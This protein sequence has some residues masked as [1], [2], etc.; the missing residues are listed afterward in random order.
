VQTELNAEDRLAVR[1]LDGLLDY[2]EALV[3][4][5]ER[6]AMRLAQHK[7]ADGSQFNL[8]QHELAGLPGITLDFSDADGPIWLCI[9]RL[10]R[11]APPPVSAECQPWIEVSNDPVK[12][13]I[14]REVRHLRMPEIEMTR[15]AA[16]GEVRT[17]D[18]MVSSKV[19]GK[20]EPPGNYFDVMLRLEDR[21]AVADALEAYCTV[22]WL[23]WSEGEKPSRRSITVYQRLFEIAQRLLQSGGHESVELIWGL[24]VA[25]W[26][27]AGESIDLPMIERGVEIEIA[28][29]S[30]AAITIR[31]RATPAR[32]EL[33]PFEKLAAERLALAEDAARRCLRAIEGADSDGVSPFR[34]ETFEPLLK[35]CGSQLDPDGRY[36]P[37]HR[38]LASTEPVPVAE[39]EILTVTDRYVLFA[40]RRSSNSVL[41]DIERFKT[42]LAPEEGEPVILKGSTRTLVM[43]PADGIDDA[44]QP[45]TDRIEE[46]NSAGAAEAEPID[47]DHGDLFFP[48]PFNDD[49]VEIIRRLEKSDGLVVQGPPGTGKTHTIA[50]IICHMLATGRRVLVVSH[51]ETALKVIRDQLPE[52]VRDLTISVTTSEREGLKQVEKA[53]GLMLGIVNLVDANPSRQRNLILNFQSS[54]AAGRRRLAE[55]DSKIA[56]IAA[57]HLSKIPG[58]SETPYEAAKRV[59]ADRPLY[60]WFT[61][62]PELH[63]DEAGIDEATITVLAEARKRIGAD[64]HFLGERFPSPANLPDPAALM[65][66][67]RDLIAATS[68]SDGVASSEPLLRRVVTKLGAQEAER[69]ATELKE[70]AVSVLAAMKE[71][72]AWTLVELQRSDAAIQRLRPTALAFLA[73]AT[74]LVEQ[75]ANFV[76]RPVVLP[77]GL[78]PRPQCRQIFQSFGEGKNPFGLLAFKLKPHQE[79]IAQIRLSGLP[80]SKPEDWRH[81][82][83]YM[84]F[85]DRV[86][87]LSARWITLRDEM[88][89]PDH[90]HFSD[91]RL[92][93]L[94]GIADRLQ[95][96]LITLP[97]AFEHATE[98]LANA[99]GNRDEAL[100]ILRHHTATSTFGEELGRYVASLRL[101]AVRENVERTSDAFCKNH[102]N[103]SGSAIQVLRDHIG[104]P[105][106]D[107]RQLE[108]VWGAL[109]AKLSHLRGLETS[110]DRISETCN[111]L[112][113]AGAPDWSSRL[114][115]EPAS[116]DGDPVIR[117]DW[118]AAWDWAAKLS[119]LE[120]IGA[121]NDLANLHRER[122]QV[123]S[124]L[125]DTFARLV[126]E[127]TFFNLAASMKGT[128]K[129]ALRAFADI[130]RRL[131]S[132]KG[133]RA[134]LYRQDSRRAM[135]N[136]YD[137]VPCWIMPTWR[138]SEQLPASFDAFDLV[139]LDE[140][141]QSD[142]RELPAL[143]RGR[144]ILVVGDDRQ[145]SPSA[146]FLSIANIGRLRENFLSEFPYRAQVE[147]G[148]S[149]YD[150]SRVMFPDK[151]VMLKEHFRCVEPIIRFSMQF[152]NEPLIPLR[153]PRGIERL[154]PPLIDILVEDGERRGKS[155]VNPP[156]AEV[157]IDEIDRIINDPTLANFAGT[158]LKPRSIG[159]ISLIGSE[160]AAFIQK[161]LMDRIG[162]AAI[163]RHRIVCGD[164]ATFQ[165]D[166]RDIIFLSMIAD[167]KRKQSQTATQYEQRFN[168]ALSRARDRMILVRSVTEN[169]LNPNDLKS[170]IIGHFRDPI[171]EALQRGAALIELCQSGFERDLFSALVERGYR[172]IPQVGSQ[173][174]SIDMVIEG[175]AGRR[176][177]VECDGDLY[178]GPER[179]A[180]D[181][182]RQR[183]L[184]RVG[185]TF[186]RTFG[187]NYSLDRERV[188]EDLFQ[189]LD[190]MGIKPL[191]ILTSGSKYTEHRTA[192]GERNEGAAA[193]SDAV[194]GSTPPNLKIDTATSTPNSDFDTSLLA[195]DRVVI[196]YLDD[197]KS[198]PEFYLLTERADDPLNG[199]L[200]VSSA[201]AKALSDSSP[202]DEISVRI[203]DRD[204]MLL[205]M[206]LEREV[207]R[208]A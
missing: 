203:G 204:R 10:Q 191:G 26:D 126:K 25:R 31:P 14:I 167:G 27:R 155:K 176:L 64:L 136:C 35:I 114:K 91:E 197:P 97:S 157:I 20:D 130:I 7:L 81:V 55:I 76:A 58:A 134:A 52:G 128:A 47:P 207:R 51:G 168:V 37:D 13:P 79:V 182:R 72:W 45:L 28:D 115:S 75:R 73:E 78:P 166:E 183:I 93:V 104:N 116:G 122:L 86:V 142:A 18:C 198:K 59:S 98:R 46:S 165:G 80:P 63:F 200:C 177:A 125:R 71:P 173:G 110:F 193:E 40:R 162:E 38:A 190:R 106:S 120:R 205:F 87:S 156:E 23:Q 187:S 143:L 83:A 180:D 39:G 206:T 9:K 32:V 44:Y 137:A 8:H 129:A 178:H 88:S 144:K 131:A 56:R 16:A 102:S 201:L 175:D 119:Y 92:S 36:L 62:R 50:N 65:E 19:A 138:V 123:E 69:F 48:K 68:L 43:G 181:M 111:R 22:P 112:V 70:L 208:A 192:K 199:L 2:V 33:R 29:Q 41:R 17:E 152:Y 139:I 103:L 132:G 141:S 54:I 3:K 150:L 89:I 101:N 99:L 170:R 30:D 194:S 74:E 113:E 6:P 171:P 159:V 1:R 140:A 172:V 117:S 49:Q 82:D 188:L 127:R 66:W 90:V 161:K 146:A 34:S 100:A 202:G 85:L 153:V 12:P 4:L 133:Q 185:W 148:A 57:T 5:D 109:L 108:R 53:I 21:A 149:L 151:F 124:E 96:A 121:A 196:R 179:W 95:A 118:K 84:L 154:D 158:E 184:E 11:T 77:K 195:G 145:V 135:E 189:T 163:I 107:A 186:W 61:D 160:Q 164:S 24:G 67:H 105:A 15:L 94:D 169:D 147:P 42:K 60:E 174:F